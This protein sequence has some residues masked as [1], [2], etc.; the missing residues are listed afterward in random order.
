VAEVDIS[1]LEDLLAQ[2]EKGRLPMQQPMQQQQPVQQCMQQPAQQPA[3]QPMQQPMQQPV[4]QPG[5]VQP[6]PIMPPVPATGA[7]VAL[8]MARPGGAVLMQAPGMRPV[9]MASI[10]SAGGPPVQAPAV[11]PAQ[12]GPNMAAGPAPMQTGP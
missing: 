6:R 4:Q 7:G 9:Q 12:M 2:L 5:S 1:L 3:Q 11:M 10:P 8:M